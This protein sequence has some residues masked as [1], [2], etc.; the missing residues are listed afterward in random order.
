MASRKEFIN[1]NTSFSSPH[2]FFLKP[3]TV[4]AKSNQD[5]SH[6]HTQKYK[7]NKETQR[8]KWFGEKKFSCTH[9]REPITIIKVF[10]K[11]ISHTLASSQTLTLQ[12][13][14]YR[15]PIAFCCSNISLTLAN[16]HNSKSFFWSKFSISFPLYTFS[17]ILKT[18][19]GSIACLVI[20]TNIFS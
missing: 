12:S 17:R 10:T 6:S 3:S 8:F 5:R 4:P 13:L 14:K 16:L 18:I 20:Y 2:K 15:A 19:Y 9:E 7:L 11:C 1:I